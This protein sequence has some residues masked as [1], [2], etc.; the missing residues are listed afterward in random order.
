MFA[1]IVVA[2]V[3]VVVTAIGVL[4]WQQSREE[5]FFVSG[6]IEA[7]DMRVGSRVG[8]RVEKVYVEEGD[9]VAAGA[10][11]VS[12]EPYDL[13]ERL[14]EARAMLAARQAELDKVQAGFRAEEVAEARARR[15]RLKARME[16]LEAGPRPL[17]IEILEDRLTA[18]EAE[19]ADAQK[20]YERVKSFFENDQA[21][22]EEM[23]EARR[24]FEVTR[25]N[26][27]AA[28]NELALAREGT[29]AEQL[30]Q[31]R[32]ALAEAEHALALLEHGYREEEVAQARAQVEAAR[33]A[34]AAIEQQIEELSVK[35]PIDCV[36]ESIELEPGDLMAPNAPVIAL[37]DPS[38]L[39]IRAYV[40]ENRLD[41]KL[42]QQVSFR[43]DSYPERRFTG[44]IAFVSRQAE[45]TP[46][47]VQTPEERS[48]QVFR[49][50]VEV[51][52]NL[53]VL[54]AGMSAD[55]YPGSSP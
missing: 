30:A 15:D 54:R 33:A 8:G 27:R 41:L 22:R 4:F 55:V 31:A 28:A 26:R 29:R 3:V 37:L 5:E 13:N 39:W 1:R 45:F 23:D 2:S 47:N 32:A 14:A 52:E 49:I 19:F 7:D 17:E 12:L 48:K 25:A 11:L 6:I 51:T 9:R 50:K 53:D 24:R 21:S 34:A 46:S 18:A 38:R 40:P 10:L 44:R 43:V 42:G 20:E 35:A 16:E 36:V